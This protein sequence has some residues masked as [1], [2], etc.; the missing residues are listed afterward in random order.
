MLHCR[1][2]LA[3]LL[4]VLPAPLMRLAKG[5]ELRPRTRWRRVRCFHW[6]PP[7]R[8]C[9]KSVVARLAFAQHDHWIS[10]AGARRRQPAGNRGDNDEDQPDKD[11]DGRFDCGNV[12]QYAAQKR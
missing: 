7:P 5:Q 4:F 9:V 11:I 6:L 8:A 12:E 10:T 3:G 2:S 1:P